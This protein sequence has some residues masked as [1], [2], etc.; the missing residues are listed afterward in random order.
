MHNFV[1]TFALI[2]HICYDVITDVSVE[3]TDTDCLLKAA[4]P[5]CLRGQVVSLYI[6]NVSLSF[7]FITVF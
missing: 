3:R 5:A 1:Q 6:V 2:V 4:G 7:S